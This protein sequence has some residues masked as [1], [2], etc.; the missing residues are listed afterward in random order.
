MFRSRLREKRRLFDQRPE[1][2][3]RVIR[4]CML[5]R[6][7]ELGRSVARRIARRRMMRSERKRASALAGALEACA[8][9]ALRARRMGLESS[10]TVFNLALFFLVAERDI[11]I[12]KV[13]A[14]THP[15]A[16]TRSLCARVIL[17]T[18]HELDLDK[19][20]GTRL[21]QAL[22]DTAA[23]AALR[24]D[25]TAA[26]RSIRAA[27][28]RAQRQFAELRHSTIAHRD[29]DAITQY[30]RIGDIEGLAVLATAAEF[31]AGT[32]AFLQVMPRVLSH[33]G[34]MSGLVSQI[35]AQGGRSRSG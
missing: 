24:Q 1:V 27:Q 28:Q 7:R 11:Q 19:A 10:E 2:V 20:G 25:L 31:Y 18:I 21:R 5:R 15:D 3:R 6:A 30:R 23:P 29:A 17:L 34:G 14:L 8:R 13:D 32:H 9:E 22:D 35:V 12:M 16:W 33:V 26:L 4:I